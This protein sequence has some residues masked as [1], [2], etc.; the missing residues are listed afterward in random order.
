MKSLLCII[1]FIGNI[2]A[3]SSLP[4]DHFAKTGQL[5]ENYSYS[6]W[7]LASLN[8][9]KYEK[10]FQLAKTPNIKDFR[11]SR[12]H[13]LILWVNYKF[14]GKMIFDSFMKFPFENAGYGSIRRMS[15]EKRFYEVD[16]ENG[17]SGINYW[18]SNEKESLPMR[19]YISTSFG[20]NSVDS[21]K[22]DYDVA[23]NKKNT[24]RPLIDE[25]KQIPGTNIFIGKM[26]IR[27]NMA[28]PKIYK[29]DQ[30]TL[31]VWFALE[32]VK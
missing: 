30:K 20:N 10:V 6:L 27:L 1:I 15:F 22:I 17:E 28:L 8:H 9:D 23:S 18:P 3:Q 2:F 5:K 32:K 11:G 7:D 16:N 4:L 14:I 24:E 29:N 26:Y 21:L 13:G 12:F 19:M 31:F 25:V